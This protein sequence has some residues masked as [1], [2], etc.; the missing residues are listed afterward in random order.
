VVQLLLAAEGI[1]VNSKA[2]CG[3]T[4]LSWAAESGHDAVVKLLQ[5]C[6]NQSS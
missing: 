4:A 3:W 2:D 5:P 1:D 6:D